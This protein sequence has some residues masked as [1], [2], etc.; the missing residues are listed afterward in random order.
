MTKCDADKLMAKCKEEE[1]KKKKYTSTAYIIMYIIGA[2]LLGGLAFAGIAAS[3]ASAAGDAK[4][5][6][7][8]AA[9]L[10]PPN[11]YQLPQQK[12]Y[13]YNY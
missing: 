2:I 3:T 4:T 8:N 7:D 9:R 5:A 6:A 13:Q 12:P 11:N 1:K 10:R